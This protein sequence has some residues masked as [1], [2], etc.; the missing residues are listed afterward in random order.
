MSTEQHKNVVTVKIVNDQLLTPLLLEVR[1]YI[2]SAFD[3]Q[4]LLEAGNMHGLIDYETEI[5]IQ[6]YA[7]FRTTIYLGNL[8]KMAIRAKVPDRMFDVV[9]FTAIG[10]AS[11]L[12]QNLPR[13]YPGRA[14]DVSIQRAK[15]HRDVPGKKRSRFLV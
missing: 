1:L 6:R 4:L 11:G 7:R 15:V 2:T 14:F 8:Q 12:K 10:H 5:D 13:G 3:C 9:S